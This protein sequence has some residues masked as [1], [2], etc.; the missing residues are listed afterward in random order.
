M[1]ILKITSIG[2]ALA[3]IALWIYFVVQDRIQLARRDNQ[4][5]GIFLVC[6]W[7]AQDHGGHM[8]SSFSQLSPWYREQ[9]HDRG[10]STVVERELDKF[11]VVTTDLMETS[12][13]SLIL[14]KERYPDSR[15]RRGCLLCGRFF[16]S[17]YGEPLIMRRRPMRCSDGFLVDDS[18]RIL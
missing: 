3:G 7:Y 18:P 9:K 15:G 5:K 16:T 12:N 6:R 1:K 17:F 8:P 13:P 14:V 2:A 10:V 11:E 4:S